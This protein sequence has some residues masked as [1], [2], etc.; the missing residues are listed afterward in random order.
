MSV[1][2]SSRARLAYCAYLL[3]PHYG[4]LSPYMPL[5]PFLIILGSP[6]LR[7]T[8]AEW[9][10]K[11]AGSGGTRSSAGALLSNLRRSFGALAAE[12]VLLSVCRLFGPC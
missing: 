3:L 12:C 11:V 5:T 2:R 6:D 8:Y 4:I 7:C 1:G 9:L 10:G